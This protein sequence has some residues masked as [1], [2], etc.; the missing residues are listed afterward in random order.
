MGVNG[1]SW[2]SFILYF[3]YILW[4]VRGRAAL[5]ICTSPLTVITE[6]FFTIFFINAILCFHLSAWW[7]LTGGGGFFFQSFF[8]F[9]FSMEGRTGIWL[10]MPS[11]N[12][13]KFLRALRKAFLGIFSSQ[14][15]LNFIL[16]IN[17]FSEVVT[18][19]LTMWFCF[20]FLNL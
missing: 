4:I 16:P 12:S 10:W 14:R 7:T 13:E 6:T 11:F 20:T 5:W 3:P 17:F 2:I 8:I 18:G 9:V 1:C 15:A 19:S